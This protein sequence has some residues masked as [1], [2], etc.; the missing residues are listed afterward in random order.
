MPIFLLVIVVLGLFAFRYTV[1]DHLIGWFVVLPLVTLSGGTIAWS[2]LIQRWSALYS[3]RGY[4]M[5]LAAFA[6]PVALLVARM[7][8]A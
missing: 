7:N 4:E 6:A 3:L 2:I 5:T 1:V 8:R